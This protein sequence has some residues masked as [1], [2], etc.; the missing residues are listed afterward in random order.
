MVDPRSL[1]PGGSHRTAALFLFSI[2]LAVVWLRLRWLHVP[3][4]GVDHPV[5]SLL[6]E[7]GVVL[8]TSAGANAAP[9]AHSVMA[10]VFGLARGVPQ[11]LEAKRRKQWRR[12][13]E[14]RHDLEGQTMVLVG[15]GAIGREVARLA[16]ACGL[17]VVAVRTEPRPAPNVDEV[18]S[19][20][21]FDAVLPA[22]DWLVLTCPLTE[23]TR[24][25]V[26]QGQ[27]DRLPRHAHVINVSRGA[28]LDE[29]ALVNALQ[30]GTIAGAYLDV[31]VEE[32]LPQESP[33]WDLENV[34][35]SP[36][37]AAGALGNRQRVSAL[38]L[39][40]LG[41]WLRGEEL[42]NLVR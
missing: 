7:R 28:V 15:L 25:L 24:G 20:D 17:R 29:V 40:N 2:A 21:R 16:K 18:V 38:F 32:P 6:L 33:L 14:E 10:A 22:A 34:I 11:W 30:R 9:V 3:N 39:E 1:A 4:A 12:L 13:G 42:K 36:H 26:G 27:L 41:R 23:R 37:D 8:T 5:F 31:F 19:L 35:L